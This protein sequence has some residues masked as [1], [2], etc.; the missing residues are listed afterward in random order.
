MEKNMLSNIEEYIDIV[1]TLI[2]KKDVHVLDKEKYV[3][4]YAQQE[5]D[6]EEQG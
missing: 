4:I 1:Q 2:K 6:Q 5:K 3:N